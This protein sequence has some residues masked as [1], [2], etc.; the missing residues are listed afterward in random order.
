MKKL[1]YVPLSIFFAL[2]VSTLVAQDN[3]F[4]K[5][6]PA[7]FDHR[8]V[9]AFLPQ[10]PKVN[11]ITGEYCEEEVDFVVA[12]IEPLSIRRFYNHQGY[13][14]QAYGHWRINPETLILFNFTTNDSQKFAG[15]GSENGGFTLCENK[16]GGTF[17]FNPNKNKSFTNESTHLTGQNHPLNTSFSVKKVTP[18]HTEHYWKGTVKDGTGRERLYDSER[19]LWGAYYNQEPAYQARII[20]ERKPNGNIIHYKYQDFNY[21]AESNSKYK[22]LATYYILTSISAHSS[23]GVFLGNINLNYPSKLKGKKP[24]VKRYVE[25]VDISGSD[26]RKVIFHNDIRTVQ[27]RRKI[28]ELGKSYERPEILDV[29]LDHVE[30]SWKPTQ[31]YNYIHDG[32]N[33]YFDHPFMEHAEQGEGRILKTEH[34]RHSKKVTSQSAPVG[35]KGEMLPIARYEYKSDHTIVYDGENHKTIFRFNK[36]KRITAVEKYEGT[37]LLNVERSEWNSSNGNLI[38]KQI[39]DSTGHPLYIREC[40]YDDN[41]NVL[42]ERISDGKNGNTIY[43][44]FSSDGFNL[45]LTESDRPEKQVKYAYIPNTNLLKT[46]FFYENDQIVKRSFHFYDEKITSARVKT[47]IDDGNSTDH[48]DLKG[49]TYRKITEIEL[50]RALPC[51]GLPETVK[52]KTIDP[53]GNEVLLKKTRYTYH[54]CGKIERED[55]YDANDAHCYSIINEYD[56]KERLIATTDPLGYRSTFEYDPN[57]NLISQDGPRADMH[58]EW[59]YDK[60]NRPI[61]ERE[62]QTNGEILVTQKKYDKCSRLT[63]DIDPCGFETKYTYNA[64]G[65]VTS[66]TYPDGATQTMEYDPL[67][68]ITKKTDPNGYVT[69]TTYNFRSQPLQIHYP[70]GTTEYSSYN[71]TGT[72]ASQTDKNG[73]TTHYTYDIFDNPIKTEVYSSQGA[74]LKA[75]SATYSPFNQLSA[76]D[77]NGV[78]THYTHDFAGRLI[79]E[80]I[81]DKLTTYAYDTLGNCSKIQEGETTTINHYDVK[82]Q[83]LEKRIEAGGETLF[84]EN[85]AYDAIGNLTETT[86]CA[87]VT[88]TTYNTQGKPI[89]QIDP[90]GNITSTTYSYK[91][92]YTVTATNPH[93]V[94]TIQIYDSRGYLIEQQTKNPT[95]QLL[96]RREMRYDASGNQTQAIEHIFNGAQFQKTIVN[97]WT[98][99]P[100]NRIERLLEAGEKETLYLYDTSGRLKT[101]IKPDQTKLYREYDD[102]GRLSRYYGGEIDYHYTYDSND[103]ILKVEEPTCVTTRSY[104]IYGYLI[105][106]TLSTGLTLTSKYTPYGNRETLQFPDGSKA[107]YTYHG[108]YLHTVSRK[109]A[110]HTYSQ[111]NLGGKLTHMILPHNLGTSEI[112]WDPNLRWKRCQTPHFHATYTYDSCGNLKTSHFTDPISTATNH[113]TY[114]DLNQL[115]SEKD[116]NYSYD[117]HYNRLSKDAHDYTLNPLSQITSDGQTTYTYDPCGNLISDEES[118]YEYDALDRL[119]SITKDKNR[120]TYTYDPFNRRVAKNNVHFLWDDKKEI[121]LYHK[122]KI[123]ELRILGEGLGAEIGATVFIE[124]KG[125]TYIPI[126]DHQGSLKLLLDSKGNLKE[127]CRYTAFGEQLTPSKLS[128]WR[129]ASKRYDDE[130]G[131]TYFGRRYYSPL[132]GRFITPDPLG[133]DDGPNLYAYVH[134]CPFT[135]IDLH[136][137]WGK[138]GFQKT[139]NSDGLNRFKGANLGARDLFFNLASSMGGKTFTST[140]SCF[141]TNPLLGEWEDLSFH[142]AKDITKMGYRTVLPYT[143]DLQ[144]LYPET[145]Q[146]LRCMAEGKAAFEQALLFCTVAKGMQG[147]GKIKMSNRQ[148]SPIFLTNRSL[149]CSGLPTINKEDTTSK[150]LNNLGQQGKGKGVREV[151]GDVQEAKTLFDKLRGKNP[152]REVKPGVF[153]AEGKNGGHVTFRTKSKSGPPTVDVHGVE[154]GIRKIKFLNE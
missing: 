27:K 150:I 130:T 126:H 105:Q 67:G 129:F 65:N 136:G 1:G 82:G 127:V 59:S 11:V 71:P 70:D 83:I 110:T 101:T 34:N 52:E 61:E 38:S 50:K 4:V 109:G 107:D 148:A 142:S 26:E 41:H 12:G 55:H 137:L 45:I 40:E 60:S 91:G 121:G 58:K 56:D 141:D 28:Y 118:D 144:H 13:K 143:Y 6:P 112:T 68:N 46:E 131:Y 88:K 81:G 154:E 16:Q 42:E 73:A 9:S 139:S 145:P 97:E 152:I 18:G 95:N 128:P 20:E 63:A 23:E 140:S 64:T 85:Y 15:V 33:N 69:T 108:P 135:L 133:F 74:L 22:Y 37:E 77:F 44:T 39:E 98:Y 94:Q 54:R 103:D 151:I 19:G 25:R 72:L 96:Q 57:F 17:T 86:T 43:R 115:T 31:N 21:K 29:V 47:I 132:L 124:L 7:V 149:T 153:T 102:L 93:Q 120:T 122:G 49:V 119:I 134:N 123:E 51:I 53:F 106:E 30:T 87:G 10:I 99:G 8:E 14:N 76:T 138:W 84:I 146:D 100:M 111:R 92:N 32:K 35:P 90:S 80:Q 36:D 113:Y 66:I 3:T 62:W 75:S 104:D 89:K 5:P 147:L 2:V 114:D 125:K 48:N 79:A 24:D 117:S 78:T 116:H